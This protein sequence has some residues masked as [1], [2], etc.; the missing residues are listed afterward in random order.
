MTSI[1]RPKL[2]SPR[3]L[4]RTSGQPDLDGLNRAHLRL[5][6]VL[7]GGIR[8]CPRRSASAS[9]TC[10]ARQVTDHL[11]TAHQRRRLVHLGGPLGH[12]VTIERREGFRQALTA[13]GIAP[14]DEEWTGDFSEESGRDLTRQLLEKGD[15]PGDVAIVGF[16]DFGLARVTTPGITTVRIPAEE[17]ARAATERLFDLIGG[18]RPLEAH[19]TLPLEIVIRGSCGCL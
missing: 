8:N 9:T 19:L 5:P 18:A 7:M 17:L 4:I 12:Q 10:P 1:D 11:I 16:D 14:S 6:V 2:S 13:A 3:G 15:V